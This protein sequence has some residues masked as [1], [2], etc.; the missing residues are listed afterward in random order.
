M[1][2]DSKIL[3][4]Y[5]LALGFKVDE[6]Q[7]KK[8]D[9]AILRHSVGVGK[10]GG[11][12][13]SAATAVAW[14]VNQVGHSLERLY[15]SSKRAESTAGNIKALEYAAKN[16]GVE[17]DTMRVALEG[18]AR[19]MRL[20]PGLQGL[21]ESLGVKVQGRD[22]ADVLVDM[23]AVLKQMPFY[24]GSQYANLFGLDPDT[25]LLLTQS[26]DRLKETAA[27]RKQ[28]A[29]DAGVDLDK[30][31][32][33]GKEYANQVR[34]VTELFGLLKEQT[35][36]TLLPLFK[37]LAAVTA[38][39]LK[40]WTQIL[41]TPQR[42][43]DGKGLGGFVRKIGEGMGIIKPGGGV[44]LSADSRKR[45]GG[46]AGRVASSF[47]TD[48][49]AGGLDT[50]TQRLELMQA[51]EG[52]YGL[53]IGI[54]EK[55]W[56]KESN[57]GD[58]K[59]MLSSKGAKGHFGFMD[60]TAREMGL[61]D[62]NNFDTSADAAAMYIRQLMD[63]YGGDV[64]KALAAY[65]W[66]MGNVD[67][68]GIGAAPWETQKYVN[69]ITGRPLSGQVLIQQKTDIHVTADS[70]AGAG[71]AVAGEQERVNANLVRDF[72]GAVQ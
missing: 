61:T 20:N 40:D 4:E 57:R 11:A 58:P 45:L 70:A 55:V 30:A 34:Q 49:S 59:Y 8:F 6:A 22:R 17:G 48:S 14:M 47:V 64:Q 13:L 43:D 27:L 28:M 26:L 53:P 32:E 7:G 3:R 56:Q 72:Q 19:S 2:A 21:L 23:L 33:A 37:D 38:G 71:R 62:P 46:R 5:L 1:A 66:G 10:L 51:L 36:I 9:T 65:N 15:Y 31:T 41:K 50:D 52:M 42:L 60:S 68:K 69:D 63:R 44:E 16:V 54:L 29:A 12:A 25:Y 67:R 35:A 39:M 18:L 24:V